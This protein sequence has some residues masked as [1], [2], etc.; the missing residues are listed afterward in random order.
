MTKPMM[1]LRALVEKSADADL[2]R[3]MTGFAAER[4][5]ERA[6]YLRALRWV[7]VGAAALSGLMIALGTPAVTTRGYGE[8]DCIDLANWICDVL[9][10]P[11]A[12]YLDGT[13]SSVDIP[14]MKRRDSLFPMGP[15]IAVVEK[16]PD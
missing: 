15:I 1:Y 2:L 4:L 16:V 7:I 10:A 13:I 9:D 12:L 6:A 3:E 11:N 8:Q 5:M 14:A